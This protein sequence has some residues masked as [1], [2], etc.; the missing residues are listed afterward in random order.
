MSVQTVS[1]CCKHSALGPR[2][3]VARQPAG[4][5]LSSR[6]IEYCSSSLTTTRYISSVVWLCMAMRKLLPAVG[7]GSVDR[8][9]D[10]SPHLIEDD[11]AGLRGR[12]KSL[13]ASVVPHGAARQPC[14]M[15][16]SFDQPN[17][18]KFTFCAQ[19]EVSLNATRESFGNVIF[20]ERHRRRKNNRGAAE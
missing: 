14:A 15:I 9:C 10:W 1:M 16:I 8:D 17:H 3:P 11:D 7:P 18:E 20:V 6:H 19:L 2:L 4:T 12:G 13:S 5:L